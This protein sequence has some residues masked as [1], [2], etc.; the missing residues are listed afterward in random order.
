MFA[1]LIVFGADRPASATSPCAGSAGAPAPWSE[2]IPASGSSSTASPR[3]SRPRGGAEV[4]ALDGI[5]LHVDAGRAGVHRR[6]LGLRQVDAAQHR[7]RARR[8][9]PPARCGS[10]AT[11]SSARARTAGWCSRRYSLFPWRSV[12]DNIA[13]GLECAGW[14]KARPSASGSTSCSGSWASR[15]FADHRP[16][17]LSGGMRQ[18]VAIARALAPEPDVLLLDEP[19][20]ALDAQTKRSMQDFLLQVRAR[21]GATI[22]MVTHDV[23]EAVYLSQR[24]YVLSL[25]ARAGW[26][27]RSTVPFGD[28]PRAAASSATRASST[29][30]TRS[31]T[32][33]TPTRSPPPAEVGCSGVPDAATL[34][35]CPPSSAAGR[36]SSRRCSDDD[37][38]A[39]PSSPRPP[40]DRLGDDAVDALRRPRRR[41]SPPPSAR[42]P[43]ASA[44]LNGTFTGARCEGHDLRQRGGDLPGV[45]RGG[46]PHPARPTGPGRRSTP[47]GRSWSKAASRTACATSSSRSST[48]LAT[49]TDDVDRRRPAAGAQPAPVRRGARPRPREV[50]RRAR[51]S[52]W[53]SRDEIADGLRVP[54]GGARGPRRRR[55]AQVLPA[56]ARPTC[57][58]TG[59][60]ADLSAIDDEEVTEL[61]LG[62]LAHGRPQ[63]PRERP[64]RRLSVD[65]VSVVDRTLT[66]RRP[67]ETRAGRDRR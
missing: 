54:E 36:S 10:A 23:A 33:S 66:C 5:D 46:R 57:A 3:P 2:G 11:S 17:Q 64:P 22:L 43:P 8:R 29:S 49:P 9:R 39:R 19:F 52:T 15:E 34:G 58:S 42:A 27:R 24:I 28:A 38:D 13:F 26:P 67:P 53:R 55:T 47:S 21:T 12:A 35:R 18:R 56:P 50:P 25:P 6:R 20:G 7:R 60:V 62:R 1:V 37:L 30:A 40:C 14:A 31:R 45:D 32:C 59:S 4:V 48:P 44:Q 16:G 41:C 51:S 65:R 63:V 61:V